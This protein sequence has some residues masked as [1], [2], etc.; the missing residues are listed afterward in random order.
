MIAA[1]NQP[2]ATLTRVANATATLE[3]DTTPPRGGGTSFRPHELLEAALGSCMAITL[4]MVAEERGMALR[5]VQVT[6]ALDRSGDGAVTCNS[7]VTLDGDLT[8]AQRAT[9]M[10]ALRLCPVRR[11][12]ARGLRFAENDG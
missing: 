5:D 10:A 11:T 8:P 1:S 7:R 3:S 12:L 9:L 4:R 6:V 2:G